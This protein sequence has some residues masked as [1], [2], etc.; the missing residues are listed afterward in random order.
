M[1]DRVPNGGSGKDCVKNFGLEQGK[2]ENP[3]FHAG[4]LR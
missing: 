3:K 1:C 2:E 4:K